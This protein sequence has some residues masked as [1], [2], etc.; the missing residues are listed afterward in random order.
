MTAR[1]PWFRVEYAMEAALLGIFMLA[2]CAY[3]VLLEHPG[4][5]VRQMLPD[6]GLR[7]VLTGLAM[8]STAIALIYS[9]WGKRSGAHMNPAIS[10]T[11]A[12][13]R[14]VAPRDAALYAA[15]QFAGAAAGVLVASLA[16]MGLLSDRTTNYAATL[17]GAQGVAVAFGAEVV[18]TFL[19][20]T[21]VL[22]VSNH[23]RWAHFTGLCAGILVALYISL[24][25]PFSGMS[26]NPARTL[27]SAVFARDWTAL[28]IYFVAPPLGMLA[29]AELYVRRRGHAA[30]FCAKLCHA[31][32]VRCLFC[33][34]RAEEAARRNGRQ[35]GTAE[36]PNGGPG[37]GTP[38]G[39]AVA[40]LSRR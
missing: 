29:A 23:P 14:K 2:A 7:R 31:D 39:S 11:F 21:V 16:F 25:S 15:A 5:P 22:V 20:M 40:S 37:V 26:M 33:E 12:R 19:L 36:R 34:W 18:I 32:G 6:V 30:V 4:S 1:A 3:T 17:P 8:G 27:G 9:P 28:W 35:G 24:E 38:D 10:L 13:L